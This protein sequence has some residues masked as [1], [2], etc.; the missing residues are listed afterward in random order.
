MTGH[1]L[2]KIE[3]QGDVGYR[4]ECECGWKSHV[5][6]TTRRT[7]A[8]NAHRIHLSNIRMQASPVRG[9]GEPPDAA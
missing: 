5:Y 3:K 6:H 2:V 9:P 4:V 1:R 7:D 8:E